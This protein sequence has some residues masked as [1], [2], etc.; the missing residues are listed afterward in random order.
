MT[1]NVQRATNRPEGL[2]SYPPGRLLLKTSA[3]DKLLPAIQGIR[4][5]DAAGVT[6][7]ILTAAPQGRTFLKTLVLGMG[8]PILRDDRI[9]L[10]VIEELDAILSDS[11][12]TLQ[13]STLAAMN[14]LECLIGFN[15]VILV[16]AIQTGGEPG[17]VYRLSPQDFISRH[18]IP[19][20]HNVD[21]FRALTLTRGLI[22]NLPDDIVVVGIEAEDVS[23]FGED[24]TPEVERSI[25]VAV[26]KILQLLKGGHRSTSLT[27]PASCASPQRKI[28]PISQ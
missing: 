13:T 16:D 17:S 1:W 24:L 10:R 18:A 8:N 21:F 12:V 7:S 14:L 20:L 4:P 22:P 6:W 15:R 19:H 5:R 28:A 25:P 26:G 27:E 2:C 11:D 9:G 3:T 23:T